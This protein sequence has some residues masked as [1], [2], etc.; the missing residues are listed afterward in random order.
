MSRIEFAHTQRA[1]YPQLMHSVID[2]DARLIWGYV[3]VGHNVGIGPFCLIGFQGV[4]YTHEDGKWIHIP[5]VGKV[6]IGD[7]VHIFPGTHIQRGTVDDTVIMDGTIIGHN[8]NIAHNCVIGENCMLTNNVVISGSVE[9]GDNVYI[10][11]NVTIR[12]HVKIAD[13]VFIGQGSN[14]LKDCDK[15]GWVY[16]GSPVRPVRKREESDY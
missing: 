8:C 10:A 9:I 4:G 2:P 3:K 1:A 14:V 16:Y 7:N 11:P 5:Q 12:D 15:P 13:N 6:I